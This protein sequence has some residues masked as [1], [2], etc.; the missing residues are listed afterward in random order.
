MVNRDYEDSKAW[1]DP[2]D[3]SVTMTPSYLRVYFCMYLQSNL[4]MEET[5][6]DSV[7][8]QLCSQHTPGNGR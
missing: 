5:K 7:C 8:W 2:E 4:L 3:K 6:P 1:H